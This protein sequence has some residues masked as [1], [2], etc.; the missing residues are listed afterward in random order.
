MNLDVG[1]LRSAKSK[2]ERRVH[3]LRGELSRESSLRLSLEESHST[4]LS[5]VQQMELVIHTEREEVSF[6]PLGQF[7][8]SIGQ[9]Y[10]SIGQF[11][12]SDWSLLYTSNEN[13]SVF[14]YGGPPD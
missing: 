1:G 10:P 6:I 11:Y 14:V 13:R 3:E 2:L 12:P 9:F 8:P 7:Y 4:L 5:R